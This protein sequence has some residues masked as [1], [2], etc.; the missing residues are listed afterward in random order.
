V[1]QTCF[2]WHI[3]IQQGPPQILRS[4]FS[5]PDPLCRPTF[6]RIWWACAG[7]FGV[8]IGFRRAEPRLA[9]ERR[10]LVQVS[11]SMRLDAS[12]RHYTNLSG[13]NMGFLVLTDVRFSSASSRRTA[14]VT[15]HSWF[16]QQDPTSCVAL[17]RDG[18]VFG[19]G[20]KAHVATKS[21]GVAGA[22][23]T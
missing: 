3:R 10:T 17:R 11:R 14:T 21:R 13:E 7:A 9:S 5:T 1:S 2:L 19:K 6:C 18:T 4:F 8:L 16:I 20:R 22:V 12:G 23:C 15:R